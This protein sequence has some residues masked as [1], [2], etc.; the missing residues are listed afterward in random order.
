MGL[1]PV[2]VR[3]CLPT[4]PPD[5]AHQPSDRQPSFLRPESPR[6]FLPGRGKMS[7]N[8]GSLYFPQGRECSHHTGGHQGQGYG[9]VG[10]AEWPSGVPDSVLP[11]RR[12]CWRGESHEA[13][14]PELCPLRLWP[15][16]PVQGL[17]GLGRRVATGE[18]GADTP[19]WNPHPTCPFIS[20]GERLTA[21]AGLPGAQGRCQAPLGSGSSHTDPHSI[22]YVP[23]VPTLLRT[24]PAERWTSL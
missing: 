21:L 12:P 24:D 20:L 18:R 7:Q 8:G 9:G 4:E 14:G 15:S 3:S 6:I 16:L 1:G 2:A 11:A 22:P 23:R 10:S 13:L 19:G 17:R 5:L